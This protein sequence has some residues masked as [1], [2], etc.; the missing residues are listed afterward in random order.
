MFTQAMR[1]SFS[2]APDEAVAIYEKVKP[3][4]GA[5]KGFVSIQRYRIVEGPYT[6]QQMVVLRFRDRAALDAARKNIAPQR[7]EALKGLAAAGA[8]VEETFLLEEI[9]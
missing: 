8:K 5:Q 3:M 7:E 9:V 2:K 1:Y 4:W 6:D